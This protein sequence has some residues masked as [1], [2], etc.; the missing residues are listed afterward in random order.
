MTRAAP[1]SGADLALVAVLIY[2]P[3]WRRQLASD[4]Q[5]SYRTV[6]R[7]QRAGPPTWVWRFLDAISRREKQG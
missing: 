6:L 1:A 3:G 2:G 7:W 4:T 5:R